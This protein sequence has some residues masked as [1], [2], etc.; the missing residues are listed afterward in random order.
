MLGVACSS[1][2]E[3]CMQFGVAV[4]S[5]LVLVRHMLGISARLP[6]VMTQV[7]VFSIASGLAPSNR[8]RLFLFFSFSAYHS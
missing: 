2:L 3:L 4:R 7:F 8:P 5:P 6:V 1:E